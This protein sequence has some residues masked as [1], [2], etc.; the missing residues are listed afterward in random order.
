MV[1]ESPPQLEMIMEED[2]KNLPL[3]FL[4]ITSQ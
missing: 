4:Q 2:E 3:N 1:I